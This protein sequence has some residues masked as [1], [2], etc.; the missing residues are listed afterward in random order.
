MESQ[1]THL[2][3]R[4]VLQPRSSC[5]GEW[6]VV[7]R[8]CSEEEKES[9][10]CELE[11]GYAEQQGWYRGPWLTMASEVPAALQRTRLA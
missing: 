11:C 6:L 2:C 8:A 5:G 9:H 7:K 10:P 3:R 1:V 4:A